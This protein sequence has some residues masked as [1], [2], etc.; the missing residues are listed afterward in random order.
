MSGHKY[1]ELA[2]QLRQGIQDGTYQTGQRL[3]SE[4]E[5]TQTTGYS[6]QTVRQAM[7]LLENEGLTDR[8]RGSGTYVRSQ[9]PSRR[10][11]HNIAVVTTYIGEYIFPDILRG[12]DGVLSG[13]GY[14]QLLSATGNR[15]DRERQILED[16]RQKPIDGLIVEGT[17]TALPNPNIDLYAYFDEQRIPV[18]FINGFY[19]DL[20][21]PV[22]VVADDRAGGR[23][24]C[25]R[26]L[27]QGHRHIAGVFKNAGT[28]AICKPSPKRG[29]LW[30]MIMC[31]GTPPKPGMIS[32]PVRPSAC[33]KAAPPWS[34]TTTKPPCNF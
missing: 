26:L 15:V 1:E 30:M 19:P 12:I 33:W 16:L 23:L 17:K 29:C 10:R 31:C 25:Q 2:R 9:V 6:R 20:T 22:Y 3:P 28:R 5:L 8:V 13:N 7:A 34:A 4:N 18:V 24:A 27:K 32:L 21:S 11:T 14:T